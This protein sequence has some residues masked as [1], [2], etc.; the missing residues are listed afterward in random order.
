MTFENNAFAG[1][2]VDQA[3]ANMCE[4]MPILKE[5]PVEHIKREIKN[6]AQN[7]N[8]ALGWELQH[9]GSLTIASDEIIFKCST[10]EAEDKLIKHFERTEDNVDISIIEDGFI[11]KFINVPDP[12]DIPEGYEDVDFR[13]MGNVMTAAVFETLG[14][15]INW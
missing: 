5:V 11:F 14:A 10:K 1:D 2:I 12:A 13:F 4:R 9:I 6:E 7:V 15:T 3:Y 8:D